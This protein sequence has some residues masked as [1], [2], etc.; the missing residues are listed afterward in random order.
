MKCLASDMALRLSGP[1]LRASVLPI[2]M[3]I[4]IVLLISLLGFMSLWEQERLH[5]IRTQ[6][7]LQAQANVRSAVALYCR[8]PNSKQLLSADGYLLCDTMP[9]SRVFL[10][11]TSWGLYELLHVAT[12]DSLGRACI[13]MGC[14]PVAS[15][16]LYYADNRM[17][18][19]LSGRTEL[20]GTLYL[21]RYGVA[22]G[23]METAFYQGADIPRTCIRQ[24]RAE[25]PE[26]GNSI[27]SRIDSLFVYAGVLQAPDHPVDLSKSFLGEAHVVTC[28][29]E[30]DIANC[31]MRGHIVFRGDELRI[32][33][34]SKIEH[35]LVVARKIVV[36][37]GARITAQLFARD[38]VIM[39]ARSRLEYPSGIWSEGYVELKDQAKVNGYVVVKNK[40]EEL[41]RSSSRVCYYQARTARVRGLLRVEGF[42]QVQGIISGYA[43]LQQANYCSPRGY[44]KNMLY[45][46]TLLENP[47][48]VMP[49][50][51]GVGLTYRREITRLK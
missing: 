51:C 33:S 1:R 47:I 3:A 39:E 21:P 6:R 26:M 36:D 20:H 38:T 34:T 17:S 13:L 43:V 24:S 9:A 4:S 35:L 40:D 8:Y 7:I 46:C 45:D 12:E 49:V 42:A 30:T 31:L 28:I 50:D 32:D 18:V 25:L 27:E 16:T 23:R 19:I 22:Y 44:Y 2:V 14:E 15:R 48:T 41:L 11:R 10:R 37:S 5:F 29:N